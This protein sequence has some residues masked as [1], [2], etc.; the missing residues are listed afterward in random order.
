MRFESGHHSMPCCSGVQQAVLMQEILVR[1]VQRFHGEAILQGKA[2]G[3]LTHPCYTSKSFC[4]L[5]A[6]AISHQVEG[7]TTS[8]PPRKPS[9]TG[10]E[11]QRLLIKR[12]DSGMPFR[13]GVCLYAMPLGGQ[14]VSFENRRVSHALLTFW[15]PL[16]QECQP[17]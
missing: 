8:Y 15:I 4:S 1:E 9:D 12:L 5:N 6:P 14:N 10:M 17:V 13:P 7:S 3:E 11:T 16:F 2:F